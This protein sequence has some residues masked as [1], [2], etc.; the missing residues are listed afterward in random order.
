[1]ATTH[2]LRKPVASR[3]VHHRRQ[4]ML[5]FA[6]VLTVAVV[7]ALIVLLVGCGGGGGMVVSPPPVTPTSTPTLS[8]TDVDAIVQAA[9][10][11]VSPATMVVA[12][13]DRAGNVLAVWRKPDATATATGNLGALVDTNDLAVGLARTGAFF[14]NNQAPLTSRTVRFISGIHFPPGVDNAGNADLYGIENTNRG[15]ALSVE[16][17]THG[18]HPSRALG[19]GNGTGIITGKANTSDSDPNAANPGGLPIYKGNVVVGGI[20]VAGVTPEVAEFAAFTGAQANGYGPIPTPLPAPGVV[21]LGGIALPAINQTT[22]PAGVSTGTSAGSYLVAPI[23]G[24]L[25]AEGTLVGPHDSV[26]PLPAGGGLSLAEVGQILD[27][28]EAAANTTRASIRLPL[29]SRTRMVI[30][31]SDMDGNIIGL[32]RMSD[33]TVFSIDVA[34]TKARNMVFFNGST[35]TDADL[36]EVPMGTATTN[37]TISF[38]AMPLYPPGINDSQPGPFFSVF[39]ND[40]AN[41]CSQGLEGGLASGNNSGIVFFPGS[42]G[43]FRNGTLVGGLG[44]SGD[45]VDQDDYVTSAGA[46]GFQAPDSIR[47]DQLIVRDVRLP[48]YKFPRN[49]TN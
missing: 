44:V 8:A 19:G 17:E 2:T 28:A 12:V 46:S 14:S 11:S 34:A 16:L 45:G 21:F 7:S 15:C 4:K 29:G 36:D 40:T 1:M 24:Q 35:R 49:P 33:A 9:L 31:V 30:A 5:A 23:A 39:L 41:P 32:R 43:L 27:N 26:N 47:A 18:I 3:L 48:Y 13:V 37:R 10:R 6:I 38:G 22:R 25:A 42:T 20:G